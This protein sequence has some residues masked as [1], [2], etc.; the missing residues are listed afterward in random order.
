MR[1]WSRTDASFG[2][3][4]PATSAV[5]VLL[6][7]LG[8]QPPIQQRAEPLAQMGRRQ[9]DVELDGLEKGGVVAVPDAA[10]PA[11]HFLIGGDDEA[12][13]SRRAELLEPPTAIVGGLGRLVERDRGVGDV[14]V[15]DLDDRRKIVGYRESDHHKDH[16]TG[17]VPSRV[18]GTLVQRCV[19]RARLTARIPGNCIAAGSSGAFERSKD[20]AVIRFS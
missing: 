15:A 18:G 10:C 5:N 2:N 12:I 20:G 11:A 4:I 3:A 19:R 9:T 14:V 17:H 1:R 13:P 6:L 7:Q 8:E 16:G